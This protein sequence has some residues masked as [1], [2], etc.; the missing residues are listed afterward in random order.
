MD[1]NR[2]LNRDSLFLMADMRV[3]GEDAEH[4][5]KVRNLSAGGMMGEGRV[6]V[7]RGKGVAVNIRNI[8]WVEGTVAW[9]QDERFGVAF[10]DEIDP[11]LARAPLATESHHDDYTRVHRTLGYQKTMGGTLR[12]I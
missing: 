12:K 10:I 8:G 2:H 11:K 6:R 3:D 5:I 4:R 7:A 1:D 9:V